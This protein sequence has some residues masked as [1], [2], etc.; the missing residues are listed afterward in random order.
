MLTLCIIRAVKVE[1]GKLCTKPL[2][3]QKFKM[4]TPSAGENVQQQRL[5]LFSGRDAQL[6]L[7]GRKMGW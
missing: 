6:V 5:L 3:R 2:E 7:L 4:L 1:Q